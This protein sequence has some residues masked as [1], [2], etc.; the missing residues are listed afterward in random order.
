[1]MPVKKCVICNKSFIPKHC[2]NKKICD[3]PKC[4]K[5]YYSEYHKQYRISDN[6]R[7]ALTKTEKLAKA[8][9]TKKGF[10]P[11]RTTSTT[12]GLEP[13]VPDFKCDNN[14]WFEVK[15]IG[16]T[17]VFS[18]QKNQLSYFNKIIKNNGHIFLMIY[19]KNYKLIVIEINLPNYTNILHSNIQ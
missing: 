4:K 12:T 6:H 1:M 17:N 16:K 2:I 14:N 7:E 18:I 10:N 11:I 5:Y 3:N 9:L 13:G 8:W 19:D 15:Y